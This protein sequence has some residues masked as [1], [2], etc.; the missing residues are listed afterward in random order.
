VSSTTLPKLLLTAPEAAKALSVCEKTL[1][2]ISVPRGT[3]PVVRIGA[4]VLYDPR[5]LADFIE[6]RKSRAADAPEAVGDGL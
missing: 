1:W 6:Q 5:D 3:L 2:S 4:R